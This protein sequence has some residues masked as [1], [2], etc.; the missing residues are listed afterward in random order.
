MVE[1]PMLHILLADDSGRGATRALVNVLLV[2]AGIAFV[3]WVLTV[4]GYDPIGW[5]ED[6]VLGLTS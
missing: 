1:A 6:T 3:V 5:V 4:A 2:A